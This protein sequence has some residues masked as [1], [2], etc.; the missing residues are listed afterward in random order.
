M[1]KK[2]YYSIL[3]GFLTLAAGASTS[4]T[5]DLPPAAGVQAKG[6]DRLTAHAPDR[7]IVKFKKGAEKNLGLQKIKHLRL[8]NASVF[9]VPAGEK[10][11]ALVSRLYSDPSIAYAEPDFQ[12]SA[13]LL[14][15]DTRF[16]ELWGLHNT[17]Q[18][19]GT[20][21]AD[22]DAPEAW[23][24][25]TGTSDVVVGVI[26]T[27]VDYTHPDLL[28]NIWTNSGEI[29]ADGVDNDG[30]GY[31]D[32]VH[33]INSITGSGDPMDDNS[34][35]YHGTHCSGTIGAKGNNSTGVAGVC[36]T[37]KIM[38]LKFLDSSGSGWTSNA[39]E[40]VQYAVDKG[41]HVLS[42]SWGGG[43][44]S[45]A[46]RDAIEAAKN[47]GILFVAAAGNSG[48]NNDIN[49]FYPSSYDNE[50]I[51]AV[52][53]TDHN[54]VRAG[55]SCYGLNSV[56]VAAPGV[57]ILSCKAGNDYQLLSGTSMATP[58]VSGLAALLKSYNLSWTWDEIKSRILAGVDP[59]PSLGGLVLTG[60]RINAFNSLTIDTSAPHILFLDPPLSIVGEDI[61]I[62]GYGFGNS[63]GAGYVEFT[64]GAHAAIV[65]WSAYHIECTVPAAAQTG[66]VTVYDTNG[67]PSNGAAFQAD[68][69]YYNE[70][71]VSNAYA[72]AGVPL[73]LRGDDVVQTYPLPFDF[74]FF[75]TT[76]PAGTSIY[77]CSNGYIDFASNSA[78]YANTREKLRASVRIAPLW[79]DLV[80]IGPAQPFEDVYVSATSGSL[81]IR[82]CAETFS[83]GDPMNF[84]AVLYPD[85]RIKFNYGPGNDDFHSLSAPG[86]TIGISC[87]AC[88]HYYDR[89]VYDNVT[90]LNLVDSDLFTS[91]SASS[92]EVTSPDASS[93][94]FKKTAQQ[95]TWT[96]SG[97]QNANVKIELWRNSSKVKDITTSTPNDGSH[98]WTPP[99]TLTTA[100]NYFIRITTIDNLVSDDS[101]IFTITGSTITVTAPNASS[102]WQRRTTQTIIWTT[103][104]T[105]A[106]KVNISLYRNNVWLKDIALGTLNDG[107]FDWKITAGLKA[108]SGYLVRVK[109]TAGNVWDDS[110]PFTITAPSITITS[111]AAGN[112]WTRGSQ[113]TIAWTKTGIQD[114]EVKIL[115]M[116]N[117]NTVRTLSLNSPNSGTFDWSIPTNLQ[118]GSGYYIQVRTL[119]GV[120]TDDSDKFTIN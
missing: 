20:P 88:G 44:Y 46:L 29:P 117:G 80:T 81:T 70:T 6:K 85:G 33:G 49:P 47:A 75:G 45:Q 108:Q 110:E 8:I 21:D 37:V 90:Q 42:N 119:D 97:P 114:D 113:Q 48:G 105:Q 100:S 54:D 91:P 120:V 106:Q 107:S 93:V 64:G 71:Q 32:D 109:T 5:A 2:I 77:I 99:G 38:G 52:A 102:L 36:W 28:D 18:T 25:A 16:D 7:I 26:D 94:W 79:I 92:L 62:K 1:R 103:Q 27:G 63:Q 74:P 69:P 15:N 60:G 95:I 3:L 43:G 76:Y 4:G 51:I 72:G 67:T 56:D 22:I 34:T 83:F 66:A 115:L 73:N 96:K 112:V 23:N 41:A 87:G 31:I 111:P 19:G 84:E 40:C 57:S 10:A 78:D 12:Q 24:I 116:R 98:T 14:P 101:E 86:P 13:I 30:N 53:A 58:H 35:T 104:G 68:T 89:S 82:W 9:K 50:N 17:G 39:V 65:S 61:H 59:L 118:V 11:T 55:F